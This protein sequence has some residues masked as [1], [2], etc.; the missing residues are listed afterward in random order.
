MLK[1]T[2]SIINAS[3][4]KTPITFADNV[5]LSTGNL[6]IGTA[7]KGID[8]S[9]TSGTGTSE[10]LADYEEGTWTPTDDSGAG[11]T[12]TL[13]TCTYTKVGRMVT[14]Y[15]VVTYPAT[16]SAASAKI[17]GFPFTPSDRT[18]G[19]IAYTS[20]STALLNYV[21]GAGAFVFLWTPGALTTNAS[22]SGGLI[23]FSA[24]FNV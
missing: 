23:I 20:V 15:A 3:Q 24:S 4:I 8:F 17:G 10:L 18:F 9:A 21:Q 6:I 14:C 13:G 22:M 2:T 7:G 5:T 16:A 19:Q 1:A 11:L 12:F